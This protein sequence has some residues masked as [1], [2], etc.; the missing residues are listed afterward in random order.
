MQ[1]GFLKMNIYIYPYPYQPPREVR[2][3]AIA[4][5]RMSLSKTIKEKFLYSRNIILHGYANK[6]E[7]IKGKSDIAIQ[8]SR[9][10]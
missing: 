4:R 1:R 9:H 7:R 6:L 2:P 8:Y 3:L 10:W 5:G